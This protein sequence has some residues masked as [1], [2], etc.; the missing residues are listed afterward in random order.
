MA[1]KTVS[2]RLQKIAALKRTVRD[3]HPCEARDVAIAAIPKYEAMTD[4]Q[5]IDNLMAYYTQW[6]KARS[7]AGKRA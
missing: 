5:F 4:E 1:K 2:A 6:G 7:P 3:G